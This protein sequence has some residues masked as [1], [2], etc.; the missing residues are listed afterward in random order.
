[1]DRPTTLVGLQRVTKLEGTGKLLL[2]HGQV[3][4]RSVGRKRADFRL[5]E[6]S[7]REAP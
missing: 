6:G 5:G 1:M 7:D 3:I 4:L 2:T